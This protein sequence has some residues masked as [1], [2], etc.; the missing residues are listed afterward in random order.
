VDASE[1][2]L[3]A[4]GRP[5]KVLLEAAVGGEAERFTGGRRI[6]HRVTESTEKT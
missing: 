3:G 1:E 6:N 2:E 5:L 4:V